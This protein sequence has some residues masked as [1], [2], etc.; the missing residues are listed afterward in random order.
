MINC[1]EEK[2]EKLL[3]NEETREKMNINIFI[4]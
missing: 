2:V 3:P 1:D 4:W